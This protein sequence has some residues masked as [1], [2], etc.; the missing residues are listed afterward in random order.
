MYKFKI[1][2]SARTQFVFTTP[3]PPKRSGARGLR[4]A[5]ICVRVPEDV[6]G[7]EDQ[8]V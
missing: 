8:Y 2:V 4:R 3:S 5:N 7:L 1:V 6:Y